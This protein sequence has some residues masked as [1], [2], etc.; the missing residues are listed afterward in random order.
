MGLLE[1][2]T[3]KKVRAFRAPGFSFTTANTAFFEI[4]LEAGIEVDC[5]VFLAPRAHGGF[6]GF[7]ADGPARVCVNG[8]HLAEFPIRP[9]QL[10]NRPVVFSGGGYF[11]LLPYWAIRWFTR[12]SS[13]V[14]TYFHPR[15][16]D[17]GQ[18]LLH[19]LTWQRRFKTYVGLDS[20]FGKLR[21]LLTEF[22]FTD[23]RTAEQSVDW[24]AC[25]TINF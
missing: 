19:G 8:R 22:N 25:R 18:P 23:L 1:S 17:P 7:G 24:P 15:D 5:S 16:F 9:F 3:G 13:Y 14:M 21:R 6:A 2:I 4:L 12:K 10:G 20:A 11:R